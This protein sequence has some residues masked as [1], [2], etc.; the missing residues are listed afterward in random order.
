MRPGANA[1]WANVR[2]GVE[3]IVGDDV[4][5]S[6]NLIAP[7]RLGPAQALVATAHPLARTVSPRR[8][9][10]V[11]YHDIGAAAS[12]TRGRARALQYVQKQ[13]AKCGSTLS[14]A[15]HARYNPSCF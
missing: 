12:H 14:P 6:L 7:D 4:Q 1:F 13:A 9:D 11:P 2:D 5:V 3:S 8:K 15:A 10:W